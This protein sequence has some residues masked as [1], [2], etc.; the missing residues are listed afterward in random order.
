[1]QFKRYSVATVTT[2]IFNYIDSEHDENPV[3]AILRT[4]CF[5]QA[6]LDC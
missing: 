3:I 4:V 5:S 1:M 2:F 6:V